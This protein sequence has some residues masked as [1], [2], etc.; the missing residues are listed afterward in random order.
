MSDGDNLLDDNAL[1]KYEA[2]R[3]YYGN[4][5]I[6]FFVERYGLSATFVMG[7]L[8]LIGPIYAVSGFAAGHFKIPFY[9]FFLVNA[10]GKM[11]RTAVIVAVLLKVL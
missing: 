10:A 1:R 11:I 8:P 4:R 7:V 5:K 6:H 2:Y 3:S 9:K